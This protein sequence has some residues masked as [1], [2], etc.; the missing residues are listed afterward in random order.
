M[1]KVHKGEGTDKKNSHLSTFFQV[2]T[3]FTEVLG[4]GTDGSWK[5]CRFSFTLYITPL[6]YYI[7]K[8]YIYLS[9]KG[10]SK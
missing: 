7:L 5:P 9:Y 3:G 8:Y 1:V 10:N 2:V 6:Y 4:F